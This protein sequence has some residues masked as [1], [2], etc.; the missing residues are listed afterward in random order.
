MPHLGQRAHLHQ[1]PLPEDGHP[2]AQRLHLAQDVRREEHR[3]AAIARLVDA[4]PE[5]LL[6]Q[7]IEPAGRLVED[8]Q[9]GPGSSGRR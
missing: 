1:L 6:H 2:V 5:C 4:E 8:Q 9:L 3:L 7:R